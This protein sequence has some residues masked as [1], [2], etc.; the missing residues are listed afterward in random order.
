M[1]AMLK[2]TKS[3]SVSSICLNFV[4]QQ[5]SFSSEMFIF[6][7]LELQKQQFRDGVNHSFQSG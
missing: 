5:A 1:S 3:A 6:S 2:T 7:W 4:T